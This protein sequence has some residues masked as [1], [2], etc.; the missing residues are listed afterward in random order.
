MTK[1]LRASALVLALSVSV[2]ADDGIMQTG[3]TP[4]PPPTTET[5]TQSNDEPTDASD[6]I[7][8]SGLVETAEQVSLSVMQSLPLI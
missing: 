2:L 4:P 1:L 7:M 3:K 8:Q 5:T 6:G